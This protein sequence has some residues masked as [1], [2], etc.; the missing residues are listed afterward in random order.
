MK[1]SQFIVGDNF[2]VCAPPTSLA[3]IEEEGKVRLAIIGE[4]RLY[5]LD[6]SYKDACSMLAKALAS[7]YSDEKKEQTDE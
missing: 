7:N 5:D 3:I 2:K 6:M 4:N 1:L